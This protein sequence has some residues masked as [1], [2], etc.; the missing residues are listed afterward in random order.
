MGANPY[1][2]SSTTSSVSS[3]DM[4]QISSPVHRFSQRD[5]GKSPLISPP[6]DTFGEYSVGLDHSTYVTNFCPMTI[7]PPLTHPA[8]FQDFLFNWAQPNLLVPPHADYSHILTPSHITSKLPGPTQN[9]NPNPRANNPIPL[10]SSIRPP[11][12]QLPC[13]PLQIQHPLVNIPSVPITLPP[14]NPST[15]IYPALPANLSSPTNFNH[16]NLLPQ[17]PPAKQNPYPHVSIIKH[18]LKLSRFHPYAPPP[19]PFICIFP[20]SHT[21]PSFSSELG[22]HSL[23]PKKGWHDIDD[24]PLAMLKKHKEQ[25]VFTGF[26]S[27]LE[28]AAIS[29]ASLKD[30]VDPLETNQPLTVSPSA[31]SLVIIDQSQG[32]IGSPISSAAGTCEAT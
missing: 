23:F 5:K 20:T 27:N 21:I 7:S 16:S 4:L 1:V 9:P 24:V 31:R 25:Q 8:N 32:S 6:A 22:P 10:L 3:V 11:S 17:A 19:P 15:F 29:L 28:M 18:P 13:P 26:Y 14:D 30:S 2:T 12:T